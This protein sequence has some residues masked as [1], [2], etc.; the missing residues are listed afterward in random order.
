[1]RF[2][3]ILYQHSCWEARCLV[4]QDD[5]SRLVSFLLVETGLRVEKKEIWYVF[6]LQKSLPAGVTP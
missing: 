2:L 1:M 5:L 6:I 3:D 4:L